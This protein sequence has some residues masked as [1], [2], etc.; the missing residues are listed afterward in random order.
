MR[1]TIECR[2]SRVRV[3]VSDSVHGHVVG[4]FHGGHLWLAD[5]EGEFRLKM[6]LFGL[7]FLLG[8]I[9]LRRSRI[10]YSLFGKTTVT[11]SKGRA[12]VFTGV[13]GLGRIRELECGKGTTVALAKSSYRVNNVPQ[14]EIV[15]DERRKGTRNSE[16]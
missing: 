14:P 13:F 10:L 3:A 11:L 16:R 6:S 15:I 2:P 12:R 7:P 4:C 9:L 1:L 5:L 8:T